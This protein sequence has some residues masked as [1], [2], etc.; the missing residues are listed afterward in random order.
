MRKPLP[1]GPVAP[2]TTQALVP[3]CL[4][5]WGLTFLLLFGALRQAG[6]EAAAT[7]GPD[8]EQGPWRYRPEGGASRNE[9]GGQDGEPR[10]RVMVRVRQWDPGT[11]QWA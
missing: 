3:L 11:S 8:A 6:A 7:P 1:G 10:P 2:S 5:A 9:A 4:W